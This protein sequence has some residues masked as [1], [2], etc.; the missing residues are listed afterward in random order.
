MRIGL[1]LLMVRAMGIVVIPGELLEVLLLLVGQLQSFIVVIGLRQIKV[2]IFL[3]PSSMRHFAL[4]RKILAIVA[5][6]LIQLILEASFI[7]K[8]E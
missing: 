5:E 3:H 7:T 2:E 4:F 6:V 1:A 8:E